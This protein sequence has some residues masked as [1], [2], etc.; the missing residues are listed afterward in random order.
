[1]FGKLRICD[2]LPGKLTTGR[3]CAAMFDVVYEPKATLCGGGLIPSIVSSFMHNDCRSS[4]RLFCNW[5][6]TQ[7]LVFMLVYPSVNMHTFKN[8]MRHGCGLAFS[9]RSRRSQNWS[10]STFASISSC[11]SSCTFCSTGFGSLLDNSSKL[12]KNFRHFS[13]VLCKLA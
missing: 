3:T 2:G 13:L 6:E 5:F 8:P 12:D 7:P 4:G 10:G 11:I 1:M 9:N